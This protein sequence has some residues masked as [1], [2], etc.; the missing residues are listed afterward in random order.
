MQL[1]PTDRRAFALV[2][3]LAAGMILTLAA[4]VIGAASSQAM[5]SLGSARDFQRAA[6]LLDQTLT[7]IDLIGPDRVSREG[8]AQGDF[9]PPDGRFQW[10]TQIESRS[11]GHLF[12][13]TVRVRWQ[14]ARGARSV[15]AQTLLNDPSDSR[16]PALKW[17]DL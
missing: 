17:D 6:Q 13:V 4:A 3:A 10:E 16:N 12:L 15:E 2:E 9:P 14:T 1:R 7:R 5:D 11:P 8:P